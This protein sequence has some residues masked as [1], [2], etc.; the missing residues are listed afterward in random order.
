MIKKYKIVILVCF[1]V[2]FCNIGAKIY[3]TNEQSKTISI[4]QRKLFA[5]RKGDDLK[6]DYSVKPGFS[7]QN[8]IKMILHKVPEEFSFTQYASKIR[9]LIDKNHLFVENSLIFKP[10]QTEVSDLLMI[11]YN[12]NISVTGS[13]IKIKKLLSDIQ[14]L[15]GL[16]FCNSARL[17]REKD[18]QSKIK[19]TL[20]LSVFFKR[21]TA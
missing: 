21:E 8:E 7:E 13:Y 18:N 19:L 3:L 10:E 1:V 14:N 12:T 15:P 17:V 6:P 11:K 5:A 4:L 20:D 2:L 16:N 9:S